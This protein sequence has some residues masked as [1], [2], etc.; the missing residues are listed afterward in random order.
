MSLRIAPPLAGVGILQSLAEQRAPDATGRANAV[1]DI[2]AQRT[3]RGRFGWKA[4]Q[5]NPRQQIAR[6]LIND[7]SV[8]SELFPED[9]CP[10]AQ[11][12][13]RAFP[14]ASAPE[15]TAAQI[16]AIEFYLMR[17]PSADS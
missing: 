12:E 8:T 1:W 10:T 13:C 4:N 3:V 6:A 14:R 7:L 16:D 11:R 15:A 17:L 2:A 9:N 5:P